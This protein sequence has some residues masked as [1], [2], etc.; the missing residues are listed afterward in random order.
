MIAAQPSWAV[1]AEDEALFGAHLDLGCARLCGL[2]RVR[3]GSQKHHITMPHYCA[4]CC[5]HGKQESLQHAQVQ[6]FLYMADFTQFLKQSITATESRPANDK[7]S[8]ASESGKKAEGAGKAQ[9]T[10]DD[11]AAKEAAKK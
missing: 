6:K 10:P 11:L 3:H 1:G 7:K 2:S 9:Q 8:A 5:C 4:H